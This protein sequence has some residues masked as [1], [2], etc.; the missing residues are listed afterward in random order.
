MKSSK[1]PKPKPQPKLQALRRETIR[2]VVSGKPERQPVTAQVSRGLAIH[3]PP[4]GGYSGGPFAVTHVASGTS[5]ATFNLFRD[6]K[7]FLFGLLD[8]KKDNKEIDWTVSND[9]LLSDLGP[10]GQGAV[11]DLRRKIHATGGSLH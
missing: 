3:K 7:R 8:M 11:R 1:T 5:I 4:L 9:Q 10:Q 6:A 2:L